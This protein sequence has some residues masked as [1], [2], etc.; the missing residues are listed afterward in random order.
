MNSDLS[1]TRFPSEKVTM[2]KSISTDALRQICLHEGADDAGFI[3]IGR[4]ALFSDRNDILKIYP[5]T[6]TLISIVKAANRESIQSPS[7]S[8]AEW[9]FSKTFTSVSDTEC[10][11]IRRLN[12]LG[13]RGTAI[14]P[15]FPMDM[16]RWPGKIWEIS[17][18]TVAVESGM[19]SMGIHRSVIHPQ[20][21]SHIVLSTILIHAK[22]DTYSQPLKENPCIKCRLCVSVCPTGA[23]SKEGN[24][25]F[26]SCMLHNY[27]E[28]LGGF[29]EW[30]EEIVSSKSIRKYRSK[31]R[32][33]ETL[34][35]WQSLTHGHAY[36]CSYCTAVCPAGDN[37]VGEYQ[38]D[39][40]RYVERIVRPLKTKHEPVYVIRGTSAESAA[41]KNEAKEI[42]YVR[43]TIRPNSVTSFLDGALLLFNKEKAKG[44]NMTLHFEFTGKETKLATIGISDGKLNV[45]EGHSG[46]SSLRVCADSETWIRMLNEE[47]SLFK[48]L[49]SGKM[50]LKGNPAHLK[51][52]K[53]CML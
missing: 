17:H 29:Q 49:M 38:S 50:K 41:I 37:T 2:N 33:S 4:D 53:E 12:E 36:R 48:A 11:V 27:H 39:K 15:A 40:K 20:L 10:R 23:I 47:I 42:R 51:K 13:I 22:L 31:F 52:F 21:G 35:K 8:V 34:C 5:E 16:T 24:F 14:P 44:L 28:L 3:E 19:G 9:E 26:M 6:E 32:D 45:E 43:N 7:R 30:I 18:K 25:D 1:E 46:K